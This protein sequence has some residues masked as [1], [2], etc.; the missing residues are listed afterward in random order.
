MHKKVLHI[1]MDDK[2]IN[3]SQWIFNQ[4]LPSQNDLILCLK[5]ANNTVI[6]VHKDSIT[7]IVSFKQLRSHLTPIIDQY[8]WVVLHSLSF[9]FSQIVTSFPTVSFI[10]SY[11]GYEVYHNTKM[12]IPELYGSETSQLFSSSFHDKT[13]RAIRKLYYQLR[14]RIDSPDQGV[15]NAA[16]QISYFATPV[17]EEF[18]MLM[19]KGILSPT[20]KWINFSYYPMEFI[21]EGQTEITTNGD[22]ILLGNSASHSNNHIEAFDMIMGL[23]LQDNQKVITPLSYGDAIY[24]EQ[25]KSIGKKKLNKHFYPL[26]DFI[27]LSQYN[28]LQQDCGFVIMNH[29]R[30]QAFGN[31]LAAIWLGAK[32]FLD[33]RNN[34]YHYLQRIGVKVYLIEELKTE[35]MEWER[36]S[37][38]KVKSNREI[39]LKHLSKEAIITS[40]D[41]HWNQISST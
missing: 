17:K 6:H 20:C 13:K 10:W 9:E 36:L 40:I 15:L 30:Q 41:N 27:P 21:F 8:K 29:Y 19:E 4:A 14:Y 33:S 22:H 11:F 31:I 28:Q 26:C 39:L 37:E 23:N 2:F 1:A 5:K 18:D 7:D 32:V 25:I 24:A 12:S 3:A 38:K 16:N 35:T 34:I